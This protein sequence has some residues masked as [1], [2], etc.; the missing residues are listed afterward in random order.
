M[1]HRGPDVVADL[2]R[3][4]RH[5]VLG[6][7]A[8]PGFIMPP[9]GPLLV[10]AVRRR[11]RRPAPLTA[12]V[13]PTLAKIPHCVGPSARS[14]RLGRPPPQGSSLGSELCCLG[15]SS[16][17]RPHPPHPRAH[18]DFIAWRLI[19]NDFAVR[20]RRG[21]PRVVPGFRRPFL[22]DM[23]S[24]LTPESSIIVAVQY[25]DIDVAFTEI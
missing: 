1:R 19:R 21:D 10:F 18:R 20:E 2:L 22:P 15:P 13:F 17:N 24:S 11:P 7:P 14:W 4:L 23:P 6:V 3:Q 25:F 8:R 16:L 9:A 12:T 5:H